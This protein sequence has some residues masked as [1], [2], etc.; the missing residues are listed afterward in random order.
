M[1]RLSSFPRGKNQCFAIFREAN[2]FE[3]KRAMYTKSDRGL[4]ISVAWNQEQ[5]GF[6]CLCGI[7]KFQYYVHWY[8]DFSNKH[9]ELSSKF[10]RQKSKSINKF[11]FP[12][13]NIKTQFMHGY[14]CCQYNL[15]HSNRWSEITSLLWERNE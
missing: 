9:V 14:Y 3:Y 7:T 12:K 10:S 15:T 5:G 4:N 2:S 11:E 8:L 1:W 6:F 13:W